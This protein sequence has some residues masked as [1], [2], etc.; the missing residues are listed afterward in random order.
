MVVVASLAAEIACRTLAR[1]ADASRTYVY[2][3]ET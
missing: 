3:A 2:W 1:P